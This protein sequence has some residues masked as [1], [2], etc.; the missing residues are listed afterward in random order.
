MSAQD[1]PDAPQ[2]LG[3][4]GDIDLDPATAERTKEQRRYRLNVVEIPAL[5]L[6]GLT[7]LI[8]L[9]Y[10][11][12]A[13]ALGPASARLFTPFTAFTFGYAGLSW[14]VLA[15]FFNRVKAIGLGLVFLT[16]DL[17]VF[18]LAIYCSGG[19]Q[20]WLYLLLLV[21]VADQ[22]NSTFRRVLTF[23]HAGP[24]GFLGLMLYLQYV[25]HRDLAWAP[26]LTKALVLYGVGFYIALT[27]RT[28][29][30][31]RLRTSAAIHLARSSNRRL[32]EASGELQDAKIR[33]EAASRAKSEFLATMSHEIRT[34]MN[35]VIG[36]A[37]LLLDTPLTSEQREYAETV[38]RSAE[39]L[40]DIINDILDFSKIEAGRL[41]LDDVEFDVETTVEEAVELLAGRV[42]DKDLELTCLVEP[43]VPPL[44]RGD[45]GRLRQIFINLI[46]NAIKFTERG[47]VVA[48]VGLVNTSGDVVTLRFEVIDTGIGIPH[49]AQARLFHSF[50]QVDGSTTRRFGGTGLGL[51]ICKRLAEL[52]GGR[53]G[54]ESEPGRGSMFWFTA[55]LRVGAS[56]VARPPAAAKSL[57]EGLRVLVVDDNPTSRA[58]LRQHLQGAAVAEEAADGAAALRRLRAAAEAGTPY[59]V[60]LLDLQ[61]PH[62]GGLEV[63]RMSQS[64]PRLTAVKL[65]LLN[66]PGPPDRMPGGQHGFAACLQK[67]VRPSRLLEC[68]AKVTAAPSAE[69]SPVREGVSEVPHDAAI[70]PSLG[71][72]LVAEDNPVNQ[73]VIARMLARLGY[74]A[75]VVGNGREAV[76]ATTRLPYDVVLMDCQM[77]EKDGLEAT[78]EIRATEAG[79]GRR[80]TIIA[81]TANALAADRDRCLAAGMDDHL[82]KPIT[83][84][85]LEEVLARWLQRR[86]PSPDP[87]AEDGAVDS[88]VECPIDRATLARLRELQ[89]DDEPD[90]LAEL[91]GL[92]LQATPGKLRALREAA[93]S[94]DATG[95]KLIAHGLKSSSGMLG[96]SAMRE[97]CARLEALGET[98][99]TEGAGPLVRL[100]EDAFERARPWLCAERW[101]DATVAS[102]A[103]NT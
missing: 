85:A 99:S 52:M 60:A 51:A 75:D 32:R 14:I 19:E 1:P 78:Q 23:A 34:P 72:I 101:A 79:T 15:L 39:A 58:F 10:L 22:V 55:R 103:A 64:D 50:S 30:R 3:P 76:E 21:R 45:P 2:A 13:L 84:D 88:R 70:G 53:I 67:P 87:R 41:E 12:N 48:R 62:L 24:L 43:D 26:A 73:K 69:P 42:G 6:V 36:M 35:G 8:A 80:L 83:R 4:T 86:G 47:E 92:F 97:L 77:P 81:L 18:L 95:L 7:I 44:L 74:R 71:R 25:E 11:H 96:L 37:G 82:A 102:P 68:L 54:V 100:L 28:A 93:E 38:R 98:G 5:R 61:M 20:S 17:G 94:A 59:D 9:V 33:A 49:A 27:A 31:L 91:F 65:I 89:G 63:A 66:P 29:E 90:V 56:S 40:L 57:L 46:G 16:A